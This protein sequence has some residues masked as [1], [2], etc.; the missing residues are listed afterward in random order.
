MNCISGQCINLKNILNNAAIPNRSS[1]VI[2]G[3]GSS[4]GGGWDGF[5]FTSA[6]CTN[7]ALCAHVLACRE[8]GVG[9]P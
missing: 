7:R 8:P 9:D 2:G 4:D 6:A 3:S 5:A 1:S